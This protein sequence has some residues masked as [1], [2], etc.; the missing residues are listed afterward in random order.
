MKTS[1]ENIVRNICR[2]DNSMPTSCQYA[3]AEVAR[4][5]ERLIPYLDEKGLPE[6]SIDKAVRCL[7]R[8]LPKYA[9]TEGKLDKAFAE[10]V[11]AIKEIPESELASFFAGEKE[12]AVDYVDMS[13]IGIRSRAYLY[14][15]NVDRASLYQGRARLP[16]KLRFDRRGE[17]MRPSQQRA[18]KILE[19]SFA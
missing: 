6:T 18:Y 11:R 7:A 8:V 2:R 16:A 3:A 13:P 1:I 10:Y 17:E 14:S 19:D 12:H 5:I 9:L 4:A 15:K